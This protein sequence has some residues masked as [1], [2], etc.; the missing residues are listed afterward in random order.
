MAPPIVQ[1]I[2]MKPYPSL[3]SLRTELNQTGRTVLIT[4]ASA[5]IGLAIARAYAEAS[6][7]KIILTGRRHDVLQEAYSKLSGTF[8]K[9]EFIPRVCDVASAEDSAALWSSLE[10]DDC[11]VDVLVLNAA[12]FGIPKP[13]LET[14]FENTWSLFEMN[15][16]SLLDFSQRMHK[17]RNKDQRKKVHN[18]S[19]SK[20]VMVKKIAIINIS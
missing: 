20:F 6:A 14:G 15:V 11:F 2:H 5:G 13:L 16:K 10:A 18:T 12:K 9:T 1:K 8:P 19:R 4:G 7:S 17:Q 3:S